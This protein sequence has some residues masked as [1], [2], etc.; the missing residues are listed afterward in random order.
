MRT[1]WRTVLHES[2]MASLEA[3]DS[4][5]S[6]NNKGLSVTSISKATAATISQN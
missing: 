4:I 3:T 5:V 1:V 6:G 2:Q